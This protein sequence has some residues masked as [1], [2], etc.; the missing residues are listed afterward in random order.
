MRADHAT[1]GAP[2]GCRIRDDFC[3]TKV[4]GTRTAQA[5]DILTACLRPLVDCHSLSVL[6]P[7]ALD[8]ARL[9]GY[10]LHE[11]SGG[12]RAR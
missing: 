7:V 8:V 4:R 6:E 12:Q 1:C 9:G 11:L 10:Y 5:A 3:S 2:E